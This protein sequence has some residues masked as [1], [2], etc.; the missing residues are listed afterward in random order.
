ML[1]QLMEPEKL[2]VGYAF[3]DYEEQHQRGL[4]PVL[5]LVGEIFCDIPVSPAVKHRHQDFPF[6]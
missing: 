3:G 6:V 4:L 5:D 1:L 2:I